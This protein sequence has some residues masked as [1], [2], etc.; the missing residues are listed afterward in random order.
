MPLA[1]TGSTAMS[2]AAVHPAATHHLPG[3]ITAPGETDVLLNVM[4]VFLAATILM[5]GILYF[6]LH[7]LPEHMAHGT[8]K[9]QLQIVGVLGLLSLFTHN[10]IYW[11]AGLLLALIPVPD[12]STPL[13]GMAKSLAKMARTKHAPPEIRPLPASLRATDYPQ[14]AAKEAKDLS[15]V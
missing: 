10:H 14:Q 6:R 11:I 7:A 9:V 13:K 8:S 2:A 1:S 3:F 12:F 5:V 4:I 15:H